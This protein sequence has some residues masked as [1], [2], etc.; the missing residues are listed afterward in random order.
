M[1]QQSRASTVDFGSDN[2][3]LAE[4]P[5]QADP[6]VEGDPSQLTPPLFDVF[7]EGAWTSA[8]EVRDASVSQYSAVQQSSSEAE[9][10]ASLLSPE[11]LTPSQASQPKPVI[12]R[13]WEDSPYG[14]LHRLRLSFYV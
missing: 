10:A 13:P 2:T 1:S 8:I 4:D 5:D 6:A 12:R 9:E 11:K 7:D 14:K 3:D